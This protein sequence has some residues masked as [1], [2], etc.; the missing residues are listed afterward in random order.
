MPSAARVPASGSIVGKN[1][2][3]KTSAAAVRINQEIV[4]FDDAS[5]RCSQTRLI[6]FSSPPSACLRWSQLCSLP[7]PGEKP[8][9]QFLFRGYFSKIVDAS[10]VP[11]LPGEAQPDLSP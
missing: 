9:D 8:E 2:L 4:P 1:A 7:A 5:R 10:G 3:L 11:G 6:A